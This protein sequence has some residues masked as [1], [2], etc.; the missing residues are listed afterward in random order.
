MM[1]TV[2]RIYNLEEEEEEYLCLTATFQYGVLSEDSF[3]KP[4]IF[5]YNYCQL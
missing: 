5:P 3:E 1:S 4:N 2:T